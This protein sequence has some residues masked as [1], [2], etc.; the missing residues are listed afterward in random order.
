MSLSL[1]FSTSHIASSFVSLLVTTTASSYFHCFTA[2]TGS[3]PISSGITLISLYEKQTGFLN[4]LAQ[5]FA[6][7]INGYNL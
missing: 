7:E 3:L 6:S 5:R 1:N 4:S 2:S